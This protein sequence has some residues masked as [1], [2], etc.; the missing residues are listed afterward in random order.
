MFFTICFQNRLTRMPQS[1]IW[2]SSYLLGIDTATSL[3]EPFLIQP[4][5]VTPL[6]EFWVT[7]P[8]RIGTKA[9]PHAGQLPK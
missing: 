9:F 4:A 6:G 1:I 8:T 7:Q 3:K 5:Q 2:F